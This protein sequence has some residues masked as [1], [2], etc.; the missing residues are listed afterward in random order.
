MTEDSGAKKNGSA[1]EVDME[2]KK[3]FEKLEEV[4][5]SIKKENL[6]TIYHFLYK[7]K[8]RG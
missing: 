1:L 7:F 8:D 4:K 5:A 6:W 2:V 3:E